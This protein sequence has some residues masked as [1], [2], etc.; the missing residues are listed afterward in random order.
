MEHSGIDHESGVGAIR[1]HPETKSTWNSFA[2][3][4]LANSFVMR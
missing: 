4:A 2:S 3:G 1:K